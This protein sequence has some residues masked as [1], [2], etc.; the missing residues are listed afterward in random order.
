[1]ALQWCSRISCFVTILTESVPHGTVVFTNFKLQ[2][3]L[4]G[5]YNT[6]NTLLLIVPTHC[7]GLIFINLLTV[8][9]THP[10]LL[11]TDLMVYRTMKDNFVTWHC[12]ASHWPHIYIIPFATVWT[13]EGSGSESRYDGTSSKLA[14]GPTQPPIQWILGALSPRIKRQGREVDHSLPT[15][16]EVKKMWIYTSTPPYIFMA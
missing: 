5:N 8:T 3:S 6:W 10:V 4:K 13:T 16:A 14:L 7:L 12:C 1:M 11:L 15:C 2:K 9:A